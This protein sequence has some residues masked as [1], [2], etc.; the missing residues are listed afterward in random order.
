[1]KKLIIFDFDGTLVDS[2]GGLAAAVNYALKE[3][4]FPTHSKNTIQGFI[5]NG[6]LSLAQKALP[7]DKRKPEI[8]NETKNIFLKYYDAHNTD[9]SYPYPGITQMLEAL[10]EKGYMI[11][12]ASN[13]YHAATVSMVAHFFPD[14]KFTCILGQREGVAVKPDPTIVFDVMSACKI[15]DKD[16]VLYVGDSDVDMKTAHNAGVD[17]CAVSWGFTSRE[18]LESLSPKYIVDSAEQFQTII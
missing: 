6:I 2:V 3:M 8:L 13:K 7:K 4:G 18:I 14:I 10:I 12:V 17:A 1:M 9:E 11:A 5:G 16:Q 15:S